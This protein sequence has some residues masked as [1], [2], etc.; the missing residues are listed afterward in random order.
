[1]VTQEQIKALAS[2]IDQLVPV[3]SGPNIARGDLITPV[4]LSGVMPESCV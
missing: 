3:Q 4:K 2:I 1:M